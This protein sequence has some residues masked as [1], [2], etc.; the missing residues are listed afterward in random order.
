M[1]KRFVLHTNTKS[2]T[3]APVA[4]GYFGFDCRR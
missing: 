1:T 3:L 4:M 2:L